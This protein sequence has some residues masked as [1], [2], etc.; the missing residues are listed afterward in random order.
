VQLALRASHFARSSSYFG[1][2]RAET[3]WYQRPE[4]VKV[5]G[6]TAGNPLPA[7]AQAASIFDDAATAARAALMDAADVHALPLQRGGKPLS[8]FSLSFRPFSEVA[9]AWCEPG[10]DGAAVVTEAD[11]RFLG[12]H[13]ALE[14][15]AARKRR[16]AAGGGEGEDEAGAEELGGDALEAFLEQA[17]GHYR[18]A[19]AHEAPARNAAARPLDAVPA[20]P[21]MAHF[22]RTPIPAPGE[23]AA[24]PSRWAHKAALCGF[25][26]PINN[27]WRHWPG[28]QQALE[29]GADRSTVRCINHAKWSPQYALPAA[30]QSYQEMRRAAGGED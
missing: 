4:L 29:R 12:R 17:Q 11:K 8:L 20:R 13:A 25:C 18:H 5:G 28:L 24:A 26:G 22:A 30:G 1:K 3:Q 6:R 19:R 16:R 15:S 2:E 9:L 10:E 23:R 7:R 14:A 21:W 27:T